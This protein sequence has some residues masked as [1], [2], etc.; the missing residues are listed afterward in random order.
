MATYKAWCKDLNAIKREEQPHF[1]Y[2]TLKNKEHLHI[3]GRFFFPHIIRGT[4]NVPTCHKDLIAEIAKP[5]DSAIIF[6]RGFAKSTWIKIDTIHDIVYGLEPV[7]VYISDTLRSAALHFTSIK[8]ELE[9]NELLRS[10]FGDLV[11]PITKEGSRKWSETH[12]ET[13]NR[14]NVVA[15]GAT[16]GRGVNIKNHRPT[17][18]IADDIEND[19]L[20][21]SALRRQKLHDWLY[22]VIFPSRDKKRGKIKVIGTVLHREAEVL[23]FYHKHGGIF[24]KAI[25]DGKS[26]WPKFFTLK[27][28]AKIKQDVGSR[29][30]AQEYLNT[31]TDDDVANFKPEWIIDNLYTVFPSIRGIKKVLFLDPQAGESAQADEFAITC[32]AWEGKDP[33]RYV[34]EQVAGRVSQ[35]DQARKVIEMWIRHPE[36]TIVGIEKVMNQTAVYQI[37]LEWRSGKHDLGI[38]GRP[39]KDRQGVVTEYKRDIPIKACS[40]GG[41][42]KVARLQMHEHCFERGEIHLRPEMQE[43]RDQILFLGASVLEHDDRADSLIGALELAVTIPS[44]REANTFEG[45]DRKEYNTIA[46]NLFKQTF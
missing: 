43:L 10:I 4:D 1:V 33:H 11:P 29:S 35:T 7:I 37:L 13:K 45:M 19:E 41:K 40:P 18:I 25:E 30:F 39:I 8:S 42:D 6:P 32:V 17:K 36:V 26:I 21:R 44:I 28:L 9:N 23:K 38:K 2:E 12:F 14:V 24:K 31:P 27:D 22:N 15:R 5:G 46:G 3:F 16:K 34:L 20:V